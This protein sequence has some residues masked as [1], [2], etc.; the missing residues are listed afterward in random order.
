MYSDACTG[1]NR[2]FKMALSSLKLVLD[3]AFQIEVIDHISMVSGQ[4]YFPNDSE[5][6]AVEPHA[7]GK[8]TYTST[9]WYDIIAHS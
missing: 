7:K 9:D 2:N 8:A 6:G 5:F 3:P 1:Q 4:S